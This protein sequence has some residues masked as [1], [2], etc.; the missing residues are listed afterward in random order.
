MVV[1]YKKMW[2]LCAEREISQ[3]ELRK[4]ANISS[5]TLTKLKK[6]QEVALSVLMK[7]AD[8]LECNAGDIMD[9]VTDEKISSEGEP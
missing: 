5:A 9:F 1:N 2:I 6:N 7:I 4:K 8:V 3:G